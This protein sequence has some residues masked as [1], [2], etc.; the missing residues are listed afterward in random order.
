MKYIPTLV[1]Y[2]VKKKTIINSLSSS[3]SSSSYTGK[4]GRWRP[5]KMLLGWLL[6]TAEGNLD[7]AQLKELVKDSTNWCQ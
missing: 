1:V 7:Y 2:C 4:E 3:L 6:K 5:S